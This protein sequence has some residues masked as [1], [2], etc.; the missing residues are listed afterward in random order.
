MQSCCG[1]NEQNVST[2]VVLRLYL[3]REAAA[4]VN[5]Q[6]CFCLRCRSV[7]VFNIIVS[8]LSSN[9]RWSLTARPS[10]CR[11]LAPFCLKALFV[12]FNRSLKSC[13]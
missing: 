2:C 5:A 9:K 3:Q 1:G 7:S 13:P 10:S 8:A 4:Q 11:L 6:V 12:F